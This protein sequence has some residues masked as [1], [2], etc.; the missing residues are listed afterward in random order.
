[1]ELDEN[2]GMMGEKKMYVK[3][4]GHYNFYS[5]SRC[6]CF[7]RPCGCL[8]VGNWWLLSSLRV[9]G[10]VRVMART[11]RG[12]CAPYE[13]YIYLPLSTSEFELASRI[14]SI[15]RHNKLHNGRRSYAFRES[16]CFFG[17][18][19]CAILGALRPKVAV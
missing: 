1:M 3:R 13:V 14:R 15:T 7:F 11:F 18:K 2:L 8:S 4:R 6:L 17:P 19:C 12:S 10:P 5:L 16:A 9:L